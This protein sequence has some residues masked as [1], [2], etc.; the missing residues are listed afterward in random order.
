MSQSNDSELNL[1]HLEA[2]AP[3]PFCESTNLHIETSSVQPDDY[4]DAWVHCG[5]CLAEGRHA[6]SLEGWLP[7]RE[8]AKAEAIAAWNRRT[9]QPVAAPTAGDAL[10]P[11]TVSRYSD[12]QQRGVLAIFDRKLSDSE[13]DTVRAALANQPAP[14]A[15]PMCWSALARRPILYTDTVGGQQTCRDDL[16]AVATAE[17]NAAPTV[18]AATLRKALRD[19]LLDVNARIFDGEA[20]RDAQTLLDSHDD[21]DDS[22]H[23]APTAQAYLAAE[24]DPAEP[25]YRVSDLIRQPAPTAAPEQVAPLEGRIVSVDVSTGE[26]DALNRIYAELTGETASD[27][28]TLIAIEQSRNFSQPSEAAPLDDKHARELARADQS[29]VTI[30]NDQLAAFHRFCDCCEDFDADGHDVSKAMMSQMVRIG[31]VRPAGPGRHET[32]EFG[33]WLRDA[34]QPAQEQAEPGAWHV[35]EMAD[36]PDPDRLLDV[37]LTNGVT[38]ES[39]RYTSIDWTQ[40]ADW[41]YAAS[42]VVRAQSEESEVA[43]EWRQVLDEVARATRKFPTWPT[44]PLHAVAVLGEEFG[45]LTKAVLQTAYEPHKVEEGELRTEAIQTAAMALRFVASLEKYEFTCCAQHSQG[46][47]A[48]R[49]AQEG[50]AHEN[51]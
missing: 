23:P 26:D 48:I 31:L 4:H 43:D 34:H 8:E 6:L 51:R 47:A 16:W 19:L 2:L 25:V 28:E 11:F 33:D 40:V 24:L 14:T 27:G 20:A 21:D 15:A 7:N 49:A 9:P 30:N 38:R 45:E 18:P 1:D 44:D 36:Q 35:L 50:G 42:P 17:L 29:P 41:R 39:L 37:V 22:R 12:T 10:P 5:D 46:R 32:T 13:L 3:C